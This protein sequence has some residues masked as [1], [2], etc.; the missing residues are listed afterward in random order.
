MVWLR[1]ASLDPAEKKFEQGSGSPKWRKSMDNH[2][3]DVLFFQASSGLDGA[4]ERIQIGRRNGRTCPMFHPDWTLPRFL[5]AAPEDE[6]DMEL[7]DEVSINLTPLERR[8]WLQIL[9]GRTIPDIARDQGV[10][11]AAIYSRIRGKDGHGGMAARNPYVGAW[12]ELRQ[13][14]T[15]R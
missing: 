5:Q 8:T 1:K 2:D 9:E 10:S 6:I 3:W 15:K 7:V 14:R 4:P 11:H 13:Q 12:W